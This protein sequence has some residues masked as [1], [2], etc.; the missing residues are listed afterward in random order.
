[1]GILLGLAAA[2]FWG[3]SDYLIVVVTRHAGT[4]R[5]MFLTQ[6]FTLL[7]WLGLLWVWPSRPAA[8]FS[9]WGLL[10]IAALC[11]VGAMWLSYRAFEIG[12]LSILSPIASG[13]III[14]AALE[15]VSHRTPPFAALLGGALLFAGII[16][17]TR[18]PGHEGEDPRA[19]VPHAAVAALGFGVMF[20]L[21]GSITPDNVLGPVW[22]LIALKIVAAGL[23]GGTLL[24][25]KKRGVA[26]PMQNFASA[27]QVALFFA[28]LDTA[29]WVAYIW[30]TRHEFTATVTA[31]GSLFSAVA[32]FLG[33]VLL[34]ERPAP[35]QRAGVGVILL[36][37]L[38]ISF[39]PH[40]AKP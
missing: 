32:V 19:G 40:F 10:L 30:G 12:T 5:A 31:L 4:T 6:G 8:P 24:L 25:E 16:L 7:S 29:A 11:Y 2:L 13:Y 23:T 15:V 22:P 35:I 9:V 1:M 17:I 18:G 39:A 27:V 26:F 33:W 14:T 21:I 20:W 36:G 37:I 3:I 28:L 34:R 38:L